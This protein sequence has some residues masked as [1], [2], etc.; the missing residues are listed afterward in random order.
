MVISFSGG[1]TSGFMTKWLLENK[2][3][4]YEFLILFANTGQESEKTLEFINNC[5]KHFGFNT[6]W[7]ESV[8]HHGERKS[9]SHKIVTFETACRDK[10][11]FEEMI[12]KHGIPNAAFP[13]CT[14]ELKLAPIN[15]YLKSIGWRLDYKTAI[16]IRADE[17]RRV[18]K[19][20]TEADICY[21][22]ID[23]VRVDKQD[24]LDWWE[25]Q[26]F[27][28]EL[29]E[30]QGNCTWCWKKSLHKHMMLIKENKQIFDVPMYFEETYP[31]TGAHQNK[32]KPR[33]FFRGNYSTKMLFK[34][35]EES[36]GHAKSLPR[37]YE[38]SGCSESCEL[39]PMET[40]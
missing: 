12:K 17:T 2:S 4:E 27:D 16:G 13:H 32:T 40:A 29:E 31:N 6:I 23:M 19:D 1:R 7:L 30:H 24:V 35:Y 28:L 5:D 36:G 22:L 34:I 26:S 15:S 8:V 3:S 18:R 9:N 20:A 37:A 21:P 10:S 39:F 25:E 11:L 38:N 14:R 33:T